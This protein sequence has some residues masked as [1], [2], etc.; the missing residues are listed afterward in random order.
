MFIIYKLIGAKYKGKSKIIW[1]KGECWHKK[2]LKL[3]LNIF[4]VEF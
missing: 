2:W 4:K 3:V 1:G